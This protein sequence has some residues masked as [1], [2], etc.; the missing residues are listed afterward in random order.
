MS[1]STAKANLEI[2]TSKAVSALEALAGKLKEVGGKA[3]EAKEKH[4]SFS[5]TLKEASEKVFFYGEALNKI[6][7][8]GKQLG[9][10]AEFSA[11]M[12]NLG[13][14]VPI[15][16]L[17]LMEEAVGHTVDKMALMQFSLKA[18]Q[19]D[20]HLT[21]AG[22]QTVLKAANNLSDKGFGDTTENANKLMHALESGRTK[23]LRDFNIQLDESKDKHENLIRIMEKL[24]K[25]AEEEVDTG[26][27]NKIEQVRTAWSNFIIDVK[28]GLGDLIA[29]IGIGIVQ[30]LGLMPKSQTQI[31]ADE[32]VKGANHYARGYAPDAPLQPGEEGYIPDAAYDYGGANESGIQVPFDYR[33]ANASMEFQAAKA[34]AIAK[35][36]PILHRGE[37]LRKP[38]GPLFTG[39][40]SKSI[41]EDPYTIERVKGSDLYA[42]GGIS[43]DRGFGIKG[44]FHEGMGAFDEGG[45]FGIPNAFANAGPSAFQQ[46]GE[47]MGPSRAERDLSKNLND[48][49]SALGGAFGAFGSGISSAV[50]AA[51]TGSESIGKAFMKASADALKSLAIESTVRALYNTAMGIGSLYLSPPAAAGYFAAAGQFALAA[52]AA[53][54]GAA[55]LGAMAGGGGASPGGGGGGA[56]M[57][58]MAGMSSFN[59]QQNQAQT[60]IVN[61]S[62]AVTAG[63]YKQ[64]G[65]TIQKAVQAGQQAGS[66]RPDTSLTIKFA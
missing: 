13:D 24:K 66:V 56:G 65:T 6:I 36:A 64:L 35:Y 25:T 21:D 52:T 44:L 62:G 4:E 8:T 11:Q 42:A 18:M 34:R 57:P 15:E 32:I 20:L 14:K 3:Q 55:A 50:D 7:E 49:S 2:D 26:T 41:G 63:D 47:A 17:H 59:P 23:E 9:E 45:L 53:G 54:A 48:R 61:V 38:K 46:V 39:D 33:A 31:N 40:V 28:S 29:Q 10:L 60:I 5:D 16:R 58:S 19:G 37:E 1:E 22:L 51:V 12:Q 30:L 43:A 27:L